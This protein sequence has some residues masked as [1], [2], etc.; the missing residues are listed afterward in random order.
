ML[1][2]TCDQRAG[3]NLGC[4]TTRPRLFTR[5][6]AQKSVVLGYLGQIRHAGKL[7]ELLPNLPPIH[8]TLD[9]NIDH[10]SFCNLTSDQSH[11]S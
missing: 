4:V 9:T 11:G 3:P 7:C 8:T 5:A 2:I 6:R 10:N 1:C